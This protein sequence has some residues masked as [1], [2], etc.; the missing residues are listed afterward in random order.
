MKMDRKSK[1]SF[2][3]LLDYQIKDAFTYIE[4]IPF[5]YINLIF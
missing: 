3:L 4:L 5:F 2:D 1:N